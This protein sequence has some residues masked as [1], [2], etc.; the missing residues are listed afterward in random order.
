MTFIMIDKD[1]EHETPLPV[2]N[3]ALIPYSWAMAG[4]CQGVKAVKTAGSAVQT[5][6]ELTTALLFLAWGSK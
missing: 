6:G 1:G 4:T 5:L 3:P 2:H